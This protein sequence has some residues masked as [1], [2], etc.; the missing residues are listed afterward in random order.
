MLTNN[1][2]QFVQHYVVL[3]LEVAMILSPMDRAGVC[4]RTPASVAINGG[5]PACNTLCR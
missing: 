4:L 3:C 5:F 1:G 2:T